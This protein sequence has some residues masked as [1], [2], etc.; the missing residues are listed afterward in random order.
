VVVGATVADHTLA[1]GGTI[2]SVTLAGPVDS[3][4]RFL[5]ATEPKRAVV[6]GVAI[7]PATDPRFTA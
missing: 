1:T 4:S 7:D 6:G 3:A 2:G 5:A